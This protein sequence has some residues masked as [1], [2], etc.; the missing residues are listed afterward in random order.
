ML[1]GVPTKLYSGA[2]HYFR[3]PKQYW[4]DRLMKLKSAGLNGVET[5]VPWNL[6]ESK[7]GKFDFSG[8]LDLEH[9]LSVAKKLDLFVLL[10]PGPYICS[11]WDWGGLPYWLLQE[12][13]KIRFCDLL[14]NLQRGPAKINFKK[15]L[16]W[17]H[18]YKSFFS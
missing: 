18:P 6:H 17:A 10:R 3:V 8:D 9:F 4:Y 12:R 2:I 5:Y 16:I 1:N 14:K 15:K 7:P 13:K 11:E